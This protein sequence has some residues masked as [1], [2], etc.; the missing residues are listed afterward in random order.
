MSESPEDRFDLPKKLETLLAVLSRRYKSQGNEV[1]LKIVVN[2]KPQVDVEVVYDNWD[3]GQSGHGVRLNVPESLFHEVMEAKHALAQ[4]LCKD[5]NRLAEVPNESFATVTITLDEEPVQADWREKRGV[6]LAARP[7]LAK[8]SETDEGR[9]WGSGRPRIFL[10]HRAEQKKMATAVKDELRKLGAAA[11]V[12]HED[13][14]PT[15]EWQAEIERALGSM[16]VLVA[17]MTEGFRA[18]HWTNQEIGVA[19]GRGIPVISVR[20]GEDPVGFIGKHQALLGDME[21]PNRI[22]TALFARMLENLGL[23][24]QILPSLVER[25]EQAEGFSTGIQVMAVL[26]D[27]STI[28]D[29]LMARLESAYKTNNQLHGSIFVRRE[30]PVFVTRM[31]ATVRGAREPWGKTPE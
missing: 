27:L 19:I 15:K 30:F 14:E 18:S 29:A 12:A 13:I 20:L 8:S 4:V 5:L 26:K 7:S 1:L 3:G 2:A 24:K 31:K 17:M 23:G 11:F 22:A 28:P 25:W 6:L 21:H 10:S 9:L 16:D